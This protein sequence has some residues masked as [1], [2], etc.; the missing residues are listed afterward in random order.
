MQLKT[1][2]VRSIKIEKILYYFYAP[3]IRTIKT[4]TFAVLLINPNIF[5]FI[6]QGKCMV[7]FAINLFQE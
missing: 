7:M 5:V 4:L 1:I 6:S 2:R 3:V